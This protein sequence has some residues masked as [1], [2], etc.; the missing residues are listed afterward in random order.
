[1][2]GDVYVDGL[3]QELQELECQALWL[4]ERRANSLV[5]PCCIEK[6]TL[7]L[8]N[9]DL[10]LVDE[11][12]RRCP[13]LVLLSLE[14]LDDSVQGVVPIIRVVAS[15]WGYQHEVDIRPVQA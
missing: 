8:D 15:A 2:E 5:L 10:C 9:R 12:D 4:F 11:S 6:A 14:R 1:V 7:H 3:S 13:H